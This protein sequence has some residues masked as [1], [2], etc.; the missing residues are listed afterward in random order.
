MY[1]ISMRMAVR[2]RRIQIFIYDGKIGRCRIQPL[3]NFAVPQTGTEVALGAHGIVV[4]GVKEVAVFP[5]GQILGVHGGSH[6][7]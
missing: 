1:V 6:F 3:V 5:S 2:M 4:A 7:R